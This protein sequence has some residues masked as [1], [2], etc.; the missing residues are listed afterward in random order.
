MKFKRARIRFF[1]LLAIADDVRILMWL[2]PKVRESVED[3]VDSK[4]Y[5]ELTEFY[6][7]LERINDR[8]HRR[9]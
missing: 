5:E 6:A 9:R 8:L 1:K 3:L 2:Y 7:A 4:N